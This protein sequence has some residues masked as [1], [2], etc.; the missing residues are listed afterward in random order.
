[1]G[2]GLSSLVIEK[3]LLG[4]ESAMRTP[5]VP[6]PMSTERRAVSATRR[7]PPRTDAPSATRTVPVRIA[8]LPPLRRAQLVT[9]ASR[10]KYRLHFS[11]VTDEEKLGG[12][13]DDRFDHPSG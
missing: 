1:M 6:R 10:G 8:V 11:S 4:S 3:G 9:S 7:C 13:A 12:C 2:S 5:G